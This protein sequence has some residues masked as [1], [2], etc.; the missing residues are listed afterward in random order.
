MPEDPIMRI[1]K[2]RDFWWLA[3]FLTALCVRLLYLWQARQVPFFDVPI[4]DAYMHDNRAMEMLAG[5]VKEEAFVQAPLYSAFLALVYKVAGHDYLAPRLAQCV[6]GAAS[7]V[8]VQFIGRRVFGRVAGVVAGFMAAFYGPSVYFEGELLRPVLVVFLALATL[9]CLMKWD[10]EKRIG[11]SAA[12]G[13]FMGLSLVTRESIVLFLPVAAVYLWILSDRQKWFSPLLFILVSALVV[14][15]VT[16]RNYKSSG[17]LV[18]VSSQGGMNFYVGN[19]AGSERLQSLQPGIEWNRMKFAPRA[20]LGRDSIPAGHIGWFFRKA[21]EDI[22]K[23]P[24]VWGR[25]MVKKLYLVFY[26]EELTPNADINLYREYSSLLR[27]LIVTAGPLWLPFGIIVPLFI[28]GIFTQKTNGNRLLLLGFIAA[29][30]LSLA[31]FHV[32]ARYRLP[33][34]PV[35][36]PFASAG[37]LW[38]ID[39]AGALDFKKFIAGMIVLIVAGVIVN[40]P[41]VDTSFA[42]QFPTHYYLGNAWAKKGDDAKAAEEYGKAL[43]L[44]PGFAELRHDYALVLMRQRR[45][46]EAIEQLKKARDI[47]PDSAHIRKKLG[48]VLRDRSINLETIA[49]YL[50]EKEETMDDAEA[51]LE[52]SRRLLMEAIAEYEAAERADP[53][54]LTLVYDLALLYARAG[55]PVGFRAKLEEY[56]RRARNKP[57]E[58]RW[59]DTAEHMLR[60]GKQINR[61]P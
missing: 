6:I 37:L 57:E 19:S 36:L 60:G 49:G 16:I 24:G 54:D 21:F 35:M 11:W 30:A 33:L 31:L 12:A 5:G 14:L 41:Q 26:A 40:R 25:K 44:R 8:M 17:L 45:E 51:A 34:A 4:I 43:A 3:V 23:E 20:D 32:R 59:V 27:Y 38:L 53:N 7:C 47:A 58:Q 2:R 42:R 52:K 55:D 18:P 61:E 46:G 22:A 48:Q 13:L 56:I 39:R 28:L 9:L 10:D 1:E 29:Y 15:P 50:I